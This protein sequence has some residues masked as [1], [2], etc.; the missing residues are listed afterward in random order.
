MKRSPVLIIDA[1]INFLLGIL[2]LS[3]PVKLVRCLGLPYT[4][5]LFFPNILGAVFIGITL[6]LLIE[7]YRKKSFFTGLGLA[8]AICINLCGG[9]V[10]AFWLMSG[11]LGI[12][13]RGQL[14]LWVLVIILAGISVLEL[15][16]YKKKR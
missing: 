13:P 11:K 6:A 8:G 2:L 1:F 5:D 12:P 16:V 9:L 10:L 7:H 3:Y 15:F 14:I 4:G